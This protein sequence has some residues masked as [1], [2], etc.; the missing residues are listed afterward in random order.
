MGAYMAAEEW[1]RKTLRV[2]KILL[3]KTQVVERA[4]SEAP[5][6]GTDGS[7]PS[8]PQ[9]QSETRPEV[10]PNTRKAV[11]TETDPIIL[12]QKRRVVVKKILVLSQKVI[13]I[14]HKRRVR[15]I[16]KMELTKRHKKWN[17]LNILMLIR[18]LA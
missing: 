1:S 17:L 15:N 14:N 4:T 9:R 3:I 12:E 6:T 10:T 8:N 13:Q 16:K 11:S 5:D 7:T 18:H 2:K